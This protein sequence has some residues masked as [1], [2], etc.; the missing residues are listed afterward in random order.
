MSSFFKVKILVVS[1]YLFIFIESISLAESEKVEQLKIG[2]LSLPSSQQPGPLIAFGQNIVNK[3]DLQLFTYVDSLQ[4]YRKS[5]TE[6]VPTL[7]YGIR[8]DLSLFIQLPVA[9]KFKIDNCTVTGVEELLVQF[10]YALYEKTQL[11]YTNQITLV[12]NIT[13]SSGSDFAGFRRAE[14]GTV[15]FLG[16]T[17]S[18]TGTNWYPFASLGTRITTKNSMNNKSGNQF[19][20]DIGLSKNIKYQP[21]KY[22]FNWMIEFTGFYEQKSKVQGIINPSSGGNSILLGPSFWFSSER[23][24]LQAGVSWVVYEKLF[25]KQNKNKYYI[26]VDCGWKF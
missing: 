5:L 24:I 17:T 14:D 10:E 9:A 23:F 2:N 4:G 8:D 13:I 18:H 21:D 11:T 1:I 3:K 26:A 19:L 20:Y 25:G 16:F 12:T 15:F 6:F 22:I 7:L